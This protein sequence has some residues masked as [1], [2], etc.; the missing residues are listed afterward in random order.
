[1]YNKVEDK[2]QNKKH[3]PVVTSRVVDM[4]SL[5]L[6]RAVINDHLLGGQCTLPPS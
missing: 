3:F 2:L 1:M 4:D 6:K 5:I